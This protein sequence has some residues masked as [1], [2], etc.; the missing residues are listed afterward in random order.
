MTNKQSNQIKNK[1]ADLFCGGYY[2][3][4]TS[5]AWRSCDIATRDNLARMI[6]YIKRIM[7]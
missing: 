4:G 2:D 1:V 3:D 5:E 7:K 6:V